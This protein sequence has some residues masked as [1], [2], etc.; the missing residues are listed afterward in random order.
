MVVASHKLFVKGQLLSDVDQFCVFKFRIFQLQIVSRENLTISAS[1]LVTNGLG[2]GIF[3]T[4]VL[5]SPPLVFR[6]VALSCTMTLDFVD[7]TSVNGNI[8]P[9]NLAKKFVTVP[10]WVHG[11]GNEGPSPGHPLEMLLSHDSAES[12]YC[13]PWILGFRSS[14]GFSFLFAPVSA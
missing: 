11:S 9:T 3:N 4:Q 1:D 10:F 8:A 6:Q 12:L 2:D 7:S 13:L 5:I 14:G